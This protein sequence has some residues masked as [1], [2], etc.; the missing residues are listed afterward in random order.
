MESQAI[1]AI[2]I[3][4]NSP[5]EDFLRINEV[6]SKCQMH[7]EMVRRFV[8]LGLIDPVYSEEKPKQ[9]LFRREV[10]PLIARIVRIRNELGINYLGVGVV[11]DLLGRIERLERQVSE[12]Q[13]ASGNII[14]R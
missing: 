1:K 4:Y 7:P 10:V 6:A 5:D 13:R 9:L 12:L 14:R 3:L 11:L 2:S 8:R